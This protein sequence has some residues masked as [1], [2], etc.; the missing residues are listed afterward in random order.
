M[1]DVSIILVGA[2]ALLVWFV[3]LLFLTTPHVTQSPLVPVGCNECN[4]TIFQLEINGFVVEGL[5]DMDEPACQATLEE[6]EPFV[7][8]FTPIVCVETEVAR[9]QS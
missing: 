8:P 6:L 1:R 9:E 4:T 5:G 7:P 3:F 2:V